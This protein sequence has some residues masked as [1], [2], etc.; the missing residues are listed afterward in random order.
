MTHPPLLKF[1]KDFDT[2]IQDIAFTKCSEWFSKDLSRE[3]IASMY[4]PCLTQKA[5]SYPHCVRTKVTLKGGTGRPMSIWRV[6]EESPDGALSYGPGS[7]EHIVR[8]SEVWASVDVT[9][10]YFMPTLFGCTL[11]ISDLLVFPPRQIFP[12]FTS[13]PVTEHRDS[14]LQDEEEPAGQRSRQKT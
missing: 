2:L 4:R 14:Q 7:A 5:E 3:Q 6:V 13:L 11:T 1:F 12:F 9:S 8:G 10:M